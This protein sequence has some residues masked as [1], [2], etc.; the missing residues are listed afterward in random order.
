[1]LRKSDKLQEES[2][3]KIIDNEKQKLFDF[4]S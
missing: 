1:M 2:K 3:A 4:V